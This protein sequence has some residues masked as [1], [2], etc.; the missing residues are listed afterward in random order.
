MRIASGPG[1]REIHRSKEPNDRPQ[2]GE[3]GA[4][5]RTQLEVD[6]QSSSFT[7]VVGGKNVGPERFGHGAEPGSGITRRGPTGA[8]VAGGWP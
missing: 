1:N 5:D 4:A 8:T 3:H 2:L 7:G 6:V